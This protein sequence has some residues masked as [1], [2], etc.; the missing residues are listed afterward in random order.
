MSVLQMGDYP[1]GCT[2]PESWGEPSDSDIC[3][4]IADEI[5]DAIFDFRADDDPQAMRDLQHVI[6][7]FIKEAGA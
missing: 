1:P 2:G 4:A 7:T 6:T 3:D 5:G